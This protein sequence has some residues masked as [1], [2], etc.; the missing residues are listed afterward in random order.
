MLLFLSLKHQWTPRRERGLEEGA[1]GREGGREG[2][3]QEELSRGK[4]NL[5]WCDRS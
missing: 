2:L 3:E 5:Q 4:A 1:G